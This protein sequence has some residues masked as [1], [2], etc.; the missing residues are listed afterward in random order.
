MATLRDFT[1][2]IPAAK[3]DQAFYEGVRAAPRRLVTSFVIPPFEGR[4]FLVD[5]G[6][7]FRVVQE[8]GVQIG[9]VSFWNRHNPREM[10][11]LARTWAIEGW[12]V[13]PYVRLWSDVPWL[14]P[15]ATCLEDTVEAGD[16]DF[17]TTGWEP[18]A[19]PSGRKCGLESRA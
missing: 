17:V 6:Q 9:D 1:V 19:P 5:G 7:S 18:T 12:V 2:L 16:G 13:T 10:Y 14:R 8:E 4:G 15:L 11:S 3:L